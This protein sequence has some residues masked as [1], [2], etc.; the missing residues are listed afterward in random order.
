MDY[1]SHTLPVT[2]MQLW[3][4]GR[5]A[6][7]SSSFFFCFCIV[8]AWLPDPAC[9]L[10][11]PSF[12][13]TFAYTFD[14]LFCSCQASVIVHSCLA[15]LLP[16]KSWSVLSHVWEWYVHDQQRTSPL[17][18]R[19]LLVLHT[20]QSLLGF[21]HYRMTKRCA[22]PSWPAKCMDQPRVVEAS[23]Q[24]GGSSVQIQPLLL[25]HVCHLI[26]RRRAANMV[27]FQKAVLSV[28]NL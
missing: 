9:L 26:K 2:I 16:R 28:I 27:G 13:I 10:L 7:A 14:V 20:A 25:H 11:R 24:T 15:V 12:L 18:F 1:N 5:V 21:K 22:T 8:M 4:S 17:T 19:R 3:S 6:K 23:F